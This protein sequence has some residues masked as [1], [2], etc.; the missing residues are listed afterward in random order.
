MALVSL[1]ACFDEPGVD[2]ILD[3]SIRV[4]SFNAPA[5]TVGENASIDALIELTKA[6]TEP[7]TV[8]YEVAT[9]NATAGV[10]FTIETPSPVTIPAGSFVVPIKIKPINNNNFETVTRALKL[11]LTS[12]SDANYKLEAYTSYSLTIINDDCPVNTSVWYGGILVDDEGY[13]TNVAATGEGTSTCNQLIVKGDLV[14]APGQIK[15]IFTPESLGA[16]KG[17]VKVDRANYCCPNA[18]GVYFQY[19]GTGTYDETTKQIIIDYKVYNTTGAL[20]FPG[21]NIIKVP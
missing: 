5:K 8:T 20:D 17:T 9:T 2:K 10:D 19:E 15:I 18:A 6:S 11:T 3:G 12:V 4:V 13:T 14:G 21:R 1:S 16:K 7:M